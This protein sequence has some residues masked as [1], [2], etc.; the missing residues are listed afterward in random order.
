MNRPTT[1]HRPLD[2]AST[3]PRRGGPTFALV[4]LLA[5]AGAALAPAQQLERTVP[6]P[7]E[8]VT[9]QEDSLFSLMR[10]QEDVHQW[11]QALAERDR[12]DF[13]S[14]VE[15]LHRLLQG[16]I[17]GTA[18]IGPNRFIGLR[19]AVVLTLANLP[20][21]GVAA[22][23][24]LVR[25]EA[26]G[27]FD[28]D[29]V[30]LRPEQL[31]LLAVRFPTARVGWRARLRLGDLALEA[32]D[33]DDASSHFD[34]AFAAA[35][36]GSA[37][38][39]TVAERRIAADALVR[40]GTMRDLPDLPPAA[41]DVLAVLPR[42]QDRLDWPAYG[43]GAGGSQPMTD[44]VGHPR[45]A[46]VEQIE[47][48][49]FHE[50]GSGRHAMQPVGSIDALF[51]ATGLELLAIDP[52]RGKELWSSLAPLREQAN[53]RS[54]DEYL[55]SVNQDMVLSAA[56]SDDVV[57]AALQVPDDQSTVRYQNAFTIMHRIPERRLFAFQ[58]STGKL[59]WSHF[60]RLE[61]PI[62]QRFRGHSS[63]GPPRIVGDTV[64][65]PVHDRAG[66]IAFY[67]GAYDLHTGA[68]R[69]RRLVC[70]SQQEVNMFGNARMEFAASPICALGGL[71]FGCS[72]LGVCYAI[73]RDTGQLRW[74]TSYDVIK[75]P[76]AA[77]QGQ[78][79][80]PVRFQNSAP[81]I[82]AGVLCC[83]PLDSDFVLGI[84]TDTGTPLWR[85]P[86]E[87]KAGGNNDVRWLCGAIGDEFVLAGRG[88]VAVPA[89]PDTLY[90]GTPPVRLVCSPDFLRSED[91]DPP[92]PAL[93]R[94][95]IYYPT[96]TG[97]SVFDLDGKAAP[98]SAEMRLQSSGNLLL[99]D[100]I[101]VS[102]AN[103]LLEVQCDATALGARADAQ[104]QT[105]ADDPAAILRLCTLRAA[106][107]HDEDALEGLYRRGLAACAHQGLPSDHP[108]H[109]AF[110]RHLFDIAVTR[111][112]RT[113]G[114]AGLDLLVAARDFAPDT[115]AFLRAQSDVL[116]RCRNDH[117]RLLREL[118]RLAA[119]A[120]DDSYAFPDAGGSVAVAAY[121]AWRHAQLAATPTAQVEAWQELLLR[122]GN[123]II[124]QRNAAELAQ[125]TIT[126]LLDEFG[127][128]IYAAVE[129]R[130]AAM[131][132][133]GGDSA[134]SLRA[135]G[136]SFPHSLAAAQAR[137]RLLDAAVAHGDLGTAVELF[138]VS[139][140]DGTES[141]ALLRRVLEAA[142]QRGNFALAQ[143]IAGRLA[144]ADQPSDWVDDGHQTFAAAVRDLLPSLSP[145]A[146]PIARAIPAELA[147]QIPSPKP[148]FGFRLLPTAIEPGF[149]ADPSP[150]LYVGF[151][152]QVRAID[153][154][155]PTRPTLFTF[156]SGI[157]DRLWRCGG[158]LIVPN[159]DR[160]VGID[161]R[162][163][164]A[165]WTLAAP[166]KML[167]CHGLV[168]GVLQVTQRDS[169]DEVLLLGIEPLTGST[170]YS[171]PLPAAMQAPQ[172]KPTD[173]DL[174]ALRVEDGRDPMVDRID[175]ITGRT[176]RSIVL[177]QRLR[178]LSHA[179]IEALQSGL[180]LQRFAATTELL[181]VRIDASLGQG[182]P[183]VLA[184][185]PTGAIAWSWDGTLGCQLNLM[186]L[187]SQPGAADRLCIVES[188]TPGGGRALICDAATGQPIR[189]VPTG[190]DVQVLNWQLQRSAAPAP[191][192]LLLSDYDIQRGERRLLCVPIDDA[193]PTF[194]Q[195]LGANGEEVVRTPSITTDLLVYGVHSPR[196]QGPVRL[197]ALH[198]QDRST[199]LPDGRGY[200]LLPV[201]QRSQHEMGAV[202]AYTVLVTDT[203]LFV[204]GDGKETR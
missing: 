68:P 81:A 96:A 164:A 192:A 118:D 67:V 151:D 20:P 161:A 180:L 55:E 176:T 177:G 22:Y 139:A 54:L 165:Q 160:I 34:A 171:R 10:S 121:V 106:L 74:I 117:P 1:I 77:L 82:A 41:A 152:D 196:S 112:E 123:A 5:L 60:D 132:A 73:E 135:V 3:Q 45:P 53:Q 70:S 11:E 17:G 27:L 9:T 12:G 203:R 178:E 31:R 159:L 138:A 141:P 102:A 166:D 131:L 170:L 105:A 199:A 47:A 91:R 163:G 29:P 84:D 26:G 175:P 202:G 25:R 169:S 115:A 201:P 104:L 40:S 186:A 48:P 35:P 78:E 189:E 173:T 147:A 113:D 18:A 107:S 57:V 98:N 101:V 46:W 162:T 108:V 190:S 61:G 8:F 39:Q 66:A 92:R 119:R 155:D 19:Y 140:R 88:V 150:L 2:P 4:G 99:I 85:V 65:A 56:L 149:A 75:M 125:Q 191:T 14:A 195:S 111:G 128:D 143:A 24:E 16:E 137:A 133:E 63:C 134:E 204:L 185:G 103:R 90:G 182:K 193:L 120:G 109:A 126:H 181:F 158:T 30:A 200:L 7:Q 146:A 167:V 114:D 6:R 154:A 72:N 50:D 13:A 42:S 79:A 184:V 129:A 97:I 80:R 36:I 83:T 51:V 157:V 122:H 194:V 37:A 59:L 172:P 76:A 198:P 21:A 94:K 69:W 64:Y 95:W 100:G 58:R 145:A 87:A 197:Y 15:R 93:S 23:E 28:A 188:S 71:L 187:R 168:H 153:V 32:G 124:R 62:S 52:L 127:R 38:E 142:R 179:P 136:R 110:L 44:P 174:L 130:A 49:G 183:H 156:K 43:G 148:P 144:T 89:R 33:G 86:Y 116:E